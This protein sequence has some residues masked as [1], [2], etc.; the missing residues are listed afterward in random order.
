MPKKLPE[1]TVYL[2]VNGKYTAIGKLY[3]RDHIGY[4]N[5]FVTNNKYSRGLHY[6]GAAPDPDYIRLETALED[7]REKIRMAMRQIVSDFVNDPNYYKYDYKM[8]DEVIQAVRE[9]FLDKKKKM[10]QAIAL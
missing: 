10:L 5:W 6:I 9:S 7:S 2:K 3:D 8:V 1:E 4:G